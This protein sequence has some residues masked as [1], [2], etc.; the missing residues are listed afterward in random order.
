M[1]WGSA[2]AIRHYGERLALQNCTLTHRAMHAA[3][4]LPTVEGTLSYNT[5]RIRF[6]YTYQGTYILG[7]SREGGREGGRIIVKCLEC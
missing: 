6:L 7:K 2:E 3:L 1:G 4:K 5:G